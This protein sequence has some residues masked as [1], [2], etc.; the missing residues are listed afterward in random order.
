MA[1]GGLHLGASPG[2]WQ[3]LVRE[4]GR[5]AEVELPELAEAYLVFLLMRHLR[6]GSLA[7]RTSPGAAADLRLD[8]LCARWEAL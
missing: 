4:G 8:A 7:A 3:D 1:D 5:R 6:D 2:L